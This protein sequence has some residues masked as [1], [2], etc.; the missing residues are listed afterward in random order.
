MTR[1]PRWLNPLNR[2]YLVLLRLLPPQVP[3]GVGFLSRSGLVTQ[4]TPDELEGLA[5]RCPVFRLDPIT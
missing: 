3:A 2:I 4:G 1:T 5:G